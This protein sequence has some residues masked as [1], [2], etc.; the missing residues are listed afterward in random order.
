MNI[1]VLTLLGAFWLLFLGRTVMLT[2]RG[3]GVFALIRGKPFSEKLIE[4]G[5]A[6]A[7]PLWTAQTASAALGRALIPVP[8][9][10]SAAAPA[11]GG[12][13][14]CA[15][16]LALFAAALVSF[17]SAWRVG[18][19]KTGD[20][21]VTSGVFALSRNPIFLF[22]DMYLFGTFLIYPNLFFL[23]SFIFSALGLHFQILKEEKSLLSRFGDAYAEYCRKV[24]R[25]I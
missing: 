9:F 17:G 5:F 23:L 13:A 19:D 16:G 24:R 21:L 15:A 4:I 1:P 22:M 10:W 20:R 14:L 7:L 2:L 18:I 8:P 12:I 11:W 3:V 25:Y 6:V